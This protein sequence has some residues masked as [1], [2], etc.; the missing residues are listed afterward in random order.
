MHSDSGTDNSLNTVVH[1]FA[2]G[3]KEAE[4]SIRNVPPRRRAKAC[5]IL[6]A[7]GGIAQ[8]F[9]S[10]NLGICLAES[11][12]NFALLDFETRLPTTAYLFGSLADEPAVADIIHPYTPPWGGLYEVC[13]ENHII[14][15]EKAA[16]KLVSLTEKGIAKLSGSAFDLRSVKSFRRLFRDLDL[17][18]INLPQNLVE[19]HFLTEMPVEKFLFVT[20]P[21]LNDVMRTF[22]LM[23]KVS[24]S[25]SS[26]VLGLLIHRADNAAH[27]RSTFTS[28]SRAVRGNL[29]KDLRFIGQFPGH[30]IIAESL[31]NRSPLALDDG[32]LDLR[33]RLNS[34]AAHVVSWIYPG[35]EFHNESE[36][37]AS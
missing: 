5:Y 3:A 16:L 10:C 37:I 11:G 33:R 36:A 18:L 13:T 22:E 34:V 26:A 12:L 25:I 23:K 1:L 2:S 19:S 27:V 9:Y 8:T 15:D 21:D 14:I 32:C 7:G 24:N 35:R 31:L 30:D 4:R 28:L 17:T 6:S 20:K 29:G